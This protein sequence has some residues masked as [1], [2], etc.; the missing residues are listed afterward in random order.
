MKLKIPAIFLVISL[1]MSAGA[2]ASGEA[3]GSSEPDYSDEEEQAWLDSFEIPE[4]MENVE[5]SP[6]DKIEL[7]EKDYE[8]V[9]R[10]MQ[11]LNKYL[12]LLYTDDVKTGV[13]FDFGG[14]TDPFDPVMTTG[15]TGAAA[16]DKVNAAAYPDWEW[17]NYQVYS[18]SRISSM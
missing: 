15:L 6:D 1:V 9:C 3:S 4:G 8:T 7:R 13:A 16:M 2:F 5:L 14:T 18:T 10:Y 17:S 11:G 12:Y